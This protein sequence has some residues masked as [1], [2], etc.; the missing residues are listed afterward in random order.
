MSPE[1]ARGQ[2]A[3]KRSDI[4][5]FGCVLFEMLTGQPPFGATDVADTLAAVLRGEP[6]WSALPPDL[7]PQ[8]RALVERCLQKDRRKR[9]GGHP[10][11]AIFLIDSNRYLGQVADLPPDAK[12]GRK[13]GWGWLW[14]A[15]AT[16]AL[17]SSLA[18]SVYIA[19]RPADIALAT[20]GGFTSR[21]RPTRPSRDTG[22]LLSSRQTDV[23]SCSSSPRSGPQART[24]LVIR[25]LDAIDARP[26]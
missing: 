10:S 16:L 18:G 2:V 21:H 1:Q 14:P 20:C 3:D 5:A 17:P 12:P 25:S 8:I 11:T 26:L 9:V 19:T 6:E 4:W 24:R 7:P 13:G 22:A 15:V 23:T